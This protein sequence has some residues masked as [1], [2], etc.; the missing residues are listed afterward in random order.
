[1]QNRITYFG[2]L[3]LILLASC[4]NVQPLEERYGIKYNDKR[5]KIGLLP[6]NSQWQLKSWM[7]PP[8]DAERDSVLIV[9]WYPENYDSIGNTGK[10]FYSEKRLTFKKDT[11]IEEVDAFAGPNSFTE[12]VKFAYLLYIY[13]FVPYEM[14]SAGWGYFFLWQ[15]D[16]DEFGKGICD[17][18]YPTRNEADSILNSWG[19]K[20]Q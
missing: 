4:N 3:F 2:C 13:R 19:L 16:E 10:A 1:M 5:E 6:L 8:R 20:Y 7:S 14:D 12:N 15:I 17:H 9:M 18:K 11:L